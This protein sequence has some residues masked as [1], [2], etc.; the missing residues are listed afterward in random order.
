MSACRV[1]EGEAG[2]GHL[3]VGLRRPM[4]ILTVCVR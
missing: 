3:T 4:Y 1:G 2:L